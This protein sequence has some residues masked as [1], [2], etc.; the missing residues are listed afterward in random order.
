MDITFGAWLKRRRRALDL[1]QD[2]LAKRAFC[3]V[4]TIRKIESGDLLPSRGLAQALAQALRVPVQAQ[5]EFV[6]LARTPDAVLHADA[7]DERKTVAAPTP[8]PA[9]HFLPPAPLSSVVGREHDV[10]VVTRLV[11]LPATRLVTLT[12]PPGTGKTRLSVEVANALE[13]EFLHGAAFVPLASVSQAS[14]VDAAV[15]GALEVRASGSGTRPALLRFLRDKELLL[16][17]DNFEHVM[18]AAPL[19]RACLQTAPRLKILVTS[20]ERLHLDGEKEIPLAP[21]ALPPLAPLPPWQDL[22][23][24]PAVQLFV[25]RARQ[26]QPDFALNPENAGAVAHICVELD[27][28]PLALEMAASRIR[29]ES[30]KQL[31]TTLSRR[32]ETLASRARDLDARQRTLRGALDWSFERLGATEQRALAYLGA[33]RGGFTADAAETVCALPS[34]QTLYA[35]VEKSLVTREQD[36]G[37]Q[38]R[39]NLFEII[40]EYAVEQLAAHGQTQ[41]ARARHAAFFRQHA[42][43]VAG[44]REFGT[45]GE[46]L[47]FD[48]RDAE[49]FRLALD[50]FAAHD[51][52]GAIEFASDLTSFWTDRGVAHEGI[53]RVEQLLPAVHALPEYNIGVFALADLAASQGDFT[54]AR[55]RAEQTRAQTTTQ[56]PKIHAESVRLLG[57]LAF[58]RGEFAKAENLLHDAE[59]EYRVLDLPAYEA[60]VWSN[61]GLIAK[62]RGEFER[63]QTY[64][65]TAL[66]V[67]RQLGLH[68]EVAQSL[69]SL[70]MVAYW[71]GD[72]ARAIESGNNAYAM[73]IADGSLT[74]AAYVL[75]TVGMAYFKLGDLERALQTLEKSLAI[76]RRTDDKRG[77]ALILNALGD[78]TLKQNDLR[79]AQQSYREALQ[80]SSAMGEKRRAAFCLEGYAAVLL[81][82]GDPGRAVTLLGASD[83]LRRA[84]GI[85][86]YAADRAGYDALVQQARDRLLETEFDQAW[87]QGCALEWDRAI[88][89]ALI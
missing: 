46:W 23:N 65:E 37:T 66:A 22:E 17:L 27:G 68:I 7:F 51:A 36:F 77:L 64:H 49:N 13:G 21:L 82:T 2:D 6:R 12:G 42:R 87:A 53:T 44:V 15:A 52:A 79:G 10:G 63:A 31:L 86:V 89:L 75:E 3:S 80:L 62:D 70:A 81:Q 1:T 47:R 59:A 60:R 25:E 16:V 39:Y 34:P 74:G 29:H 41:D 40:R 11:R 28:L 88:A 48:A 84:V 32:L 20:R 69:Y 58:M 56:Q 33:F 73:R 71:Q 14:Q 78:V 18:D 83:A 24:F 9:L 57:F 45:H 50:W 26:V 67:R 30:P 54:Q 72:Y 8:P 5:G 76:L 55:V 38:A 35:L 85:P 43:A 61:L 19:V 4:N